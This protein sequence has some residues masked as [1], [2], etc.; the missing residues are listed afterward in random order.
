VKGATGKD[1]PMCADLGGNDGYYFT[2]HDIPTA[3]IG[4]IAD[5]ANYHGIDEW[6]SIKDYDVVKDA[7]IRFA[8]M[9]E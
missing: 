9:C 7:L 4:T 8:E 2:M 3:C 5:D 1:L 6:L